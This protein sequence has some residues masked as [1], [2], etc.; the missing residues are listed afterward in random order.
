MND[1]QKNGVIGMGFGPLMNMKLKELPM[2][3]AYWLLENFDENTCEIIINDGKRRLHIEEQDVWLTLGMPKG[4]TNLKMKT[5]SQYPEI[6]EEWNAI[7]SHHDLKKISP[8][9]LSIKMLQETDGGAWFK[10]YFLLLMAACMIEG[11]S[12]GY[13]QPRLLV[14]FED[15]TKVKDFNWCSY[16]LKVLV[17]QKGKW[18]LSKKNHFLGPISFLLVIFLL[19]T[20]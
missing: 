5:R 14:N 6:Y 1:A 3:L 10:R 8:T 12:S 2:K 7:F 17:D 11:S 9:V 4:N 15:I 19:N 13:I 16:V 20:N 18:A